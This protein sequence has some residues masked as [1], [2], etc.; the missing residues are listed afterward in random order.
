M[1][2]SPSYTRRQIGG[3]TNLHNFAYGEQLKELVSTEQTAND[4]FNMTLQNI[5]LIGSTGRI[6]TAIRKALVSHKSQF[7]KIGAL[8]TSESLSDAKKKESFDT[9]QSEGVQIVVADFDDHNTLTQAL[10]GTF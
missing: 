6:G 1:S 7:N 4:L 10:K 5:L 8:T 9:I 3:L 2:C